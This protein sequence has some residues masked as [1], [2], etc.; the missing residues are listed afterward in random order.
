VTTTG[1]PAWFEQGPGENTGGQVQNVTPDNQV[2]GAVNALAADPA[3]ANIL[4]AAT[5]NGG[6]WKTTNA[7]AANPSWFPLTDHYPSLSVGDI[8]MNPTNSNVLYAGTS[9]VSSSG[10]GENTTGLLRTTDGGNTWTILGQSTFG[11]QNIIKVRPTDLS[12]GAVVVV[13]TSSGVYRSTDS[14]A[15]WTLISGTGGLPL[16]GTTDMVRDPTALHR[17][18]V[19]IPSTAARVF[20]SEDGGLTWVAA[21]LPATAGRIR[22]TIGAGSTVYAATMNSQLTN[23]FRSATLGASWVSMGVPSP[24]IHPGGQAGLHFSFLGDSANPNVVFIGGDRQ[25]S[26]FTNGCNNFTGNHFR[27]VFGSGWTS[28]DCN[29]ATLGGSPTSSHADSRSLAFDANGNLL[30]TDDGGIYR[31]INPN[32]AANTRRW[33]SVIGS[34]VGI[35]PTEFYSI[36]YDSVNHVL[37]GGAQDTGSPE[38]TAQNSFTWRDTSQAD[39]GTV[40]SDNTSVANQ[41]AHYSSSQALGGF[42]RR[43]FN[44]AGI[45]LSDVGVP[46]RIAGTT[47]T[48]TARDAAGNLTFD[49][50]VQFTQPY[51]LNN[52]DARRMVIGTNFL[53]ESTDRGDD[54]TSVGGVSGGH[55]TNPIGFV[56]GI[57]YGGVSGGVPNTQVLWIGAGGQLRERS[58]GTGLPAVVGTYPGSSVQS[59]RMDPT[60]WHTAYV[61]DTFGRVWR[62]TNTGASWTNLT[63]NLASLTPSARVIEVV[64]IGANVAILVGG[65]GGV[66]RA[67]NP[68]ATATW[69]RFGSSESNAIVR[70]LHYNATD[71]VLVVGTLGRGAWKVTSAS[72][73]LFQTSVVTVDGTAGNDVITLARDPNIPGILNVFLNSVT[74]VF[75]VVAAAVQQIIVNGLGGNDTININDSFT[76]TPVT[77]N[78]STAGCTVNISSVEHS[79][80]HIQANVQVNGASTGTDVLNVNDQANGA[81]TYLLTPSSLARSGS[82][83][84]LI[85][86]LINTITLNGSNGANTYTVNGTN[87]FTSS[88][89]INTGTGSDVIDVEATTRPLIIQEQG[90]S[91]DVVHISQVGHTLSNIQGTV[92]VNGNSGTDTLNVNDQNGPAGALT[93]AMASNAVSRG[94]AAAINYTA[95]NVVVVNGSNGPDTYNITGTESFFSTTVNGG[96]GGN[97]VNVFATSG[98]LAVNSG[99]GNDVINV[100]SGGGG[101]TINNIQ[102]NVTVNGQAGLNSLFINDQGNPPVPGRVYTITST[103]VSRTGPP[104]AVGTITYS[105][106][107]TLVVNGSS[108]YVVQSTPTGTTTTLNCGPGDDT[109]AI[110]NA[111]NTLD[112]IQGLLTVNGQAGNNS[113]TFNDQGNP[114]AQSYSLSAST[115]SRSGMATI[116]FLNVQTV[117]LNGGNGGNT[118]GVLSTA[119]GVTTT[120][121]AGNGNNALSVGDGGSTLDGI[122][123]PLTVD[124]QGGTNTLALNDGG[125]LAAQNYSLTA[126]TLDRSAMATISYLNMQALSLDGS[127]AGGSAFVITAIMDTFPTALNS[128]GLGDVV[129]VQGTSAT[130]TLTITTNGGS[131]I[132]GLHNAGNTVDGIANVTVNDP[133]ASSTVTVDDFGFSGDETYT[134]TGTTVDV[135]RLGV[136]LLVYAN[137]DSLVVNGGNAVAGDLFSIDSTSAPGGTAINSGAGPD[138]FSI[139][140]FSL[141]LASIAGPLT[142]NG[143]GGDTISFWDTANPAAETYNFDAIPS[144]LTLTTVPV[145]INFTGMA[146]VYLQTNGSSTVNDP[147]GTVIV[148]G[149]PPC[150]P[151]QGPGYGAP[152]VG[153]DVQGAALPGRTSL[154]NG[155]RRAALPT[156]DALAGSLVHRIASKPDPWEF[157]IEE[158]LPENVLRV[159]ATDWAI[160]TLQ[161]RFRR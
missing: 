65:Q 78:M 61:L 62:T 141:Y 144:M 66:F 40:A 45:L 2:A 39:G 102:G 3:N 110:G 73:T 50:T 64:H 5:V 112:G 150:L 47:T 142:V 124:G 100:G 85:N 18:Y 1:I 92:T 51:V 74:P 138:C 151:N 56:R 22:L 130:G 76:G 49:N 152:V 55:P 114:A 43:T 53:Y 15:N 89:T 111:G 94:G 80:S 21:T 41:S 10:D 57:D 160:A 122:Q 26:P 155:A 46:L 29:G 148:D 105:N 107:Q 96:G 98:A 70:D 75:S 101:S 127:G 90:S 68:G 36:A 77:V 12:G 67:L 38:Q 108:N 143:S 24:T 82:A 145:S 87:S 109:I 147:S 117:T 88:T 58:S 91:N 60:D 118:I 113:L 9:R 132:V 44:N 79:L 149:S 17:L 37:M 86:N 25:A 71:N 126:T 20:R 133:T 63:G 120:V 7:T 146:A 136:S 42:H 128:N 19:A 33:V 8:N 103:A 31:L 139:S 4:Y 54:L 6:V 14:G 84:I 16:G 23:V 134:V 59:V 81:G 30:E 34:S 27:G 159:L 119:S 95:I 116:T 52:A 32:G 123:G 154:G 106:I 97:T 104:V 140:P 156:A 48:L 13:A 158:P 121:N 93:Y 137:I 69:S 35:R 129:G 125:N 11:G 153:E 135:A 28:M 99:S 157:A 131:T 72:T 161:R 115:L 83:T